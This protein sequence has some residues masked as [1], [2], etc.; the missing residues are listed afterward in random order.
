M[1]IIILF[2]RDI[3]WDNCS[4][5]AEKNDRR[6]MYANALLAWGAL[7]WSIPLATIQALA[8]AEQVGEC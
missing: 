7:L 6:S 2:F 3:L 1:V 8:S 4:E 5:S